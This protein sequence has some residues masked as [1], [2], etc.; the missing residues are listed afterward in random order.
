MNPESGPQSINSD[1]ETAMHLKSAEDHNLTSNYDSHGPSCQKDCCKT[2]SL[3]LMFQK[4]I[5]PIQFIEIPGLS[6]R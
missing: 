5:Q 1:S 4:V 2:E 3:V 6:S